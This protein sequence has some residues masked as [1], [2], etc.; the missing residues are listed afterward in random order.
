MIDTEEETAKKSQHAV[1]FQTMETSELP[2]IHHRVKTHNELPFFV[3]EWRHVI[4]NMK[5]TQAP[6]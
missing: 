3:G 6:K 2:F 1:N 5:E 4:W